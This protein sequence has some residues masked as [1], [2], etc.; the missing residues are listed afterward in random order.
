MAQRRGFFSQQGRL[1]LSPDP[2]TK[3]EKTT[4]FIICSCGL[5]SQLCHVWLLFT[6]ELCAARVHRMITKYMSF[7]RKYLPKNFNLCMYFL[8]G[9]EKNVHQKQLQLP[10]TLPRVFTPT[11]HLTSRA[12]TKTSDARCNNKMRWLKGLLN[13][14]S[15]K[16]GKGCT[17]GARRCLLTRISVLHISCY[18]TKGNPS[19]SWIRLQHDVCKR[20][21]RR[22]VIEGRKG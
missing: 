5:F 11:K 17:I 7:L 21:V 1:P 13:L 12:I 9:R 3:I 2:N 15:S 10:T 16:Q 14:C 8:L 6:C 19:Q 4:L 22:R 20:L 18:T